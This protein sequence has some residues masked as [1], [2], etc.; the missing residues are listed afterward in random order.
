MTAP[1]GTHLWPGLAG[2]ALMIRRCEC[3]ALLLA[4]VAVTCSSCGS[5]HLSRVPSSGV[6]SM[7]T[8]KVAERVRVGSYDD[9]MPCML[10]VVALDDG[11]WICSWIEGEVAIRPGRSVRVQFDHLEADERYPVFHGCQ[12]VPAVQVA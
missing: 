9:A 1:G 11:P 12:R 3:C 2:G 10:A 7:I 6:G 8:W 4:P 5:G